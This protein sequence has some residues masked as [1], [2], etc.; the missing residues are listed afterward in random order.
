MACEKTSPWTSVSCAAV[1]GL[2]AS[3]TVEANCPAASSGCAPGRSLQY[4][5]SFGQ[6][7]CV[8]LRFVFVSKTS[9][10]TTPS[11][12]TTNWSCLDVSLGDFAFTSVSAYSMFAQAT[13]PAVIDVL[14]AWPPSGCAASAEAQDQTKPRHRAAAWSWIGPRTPVKTSPNN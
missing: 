4:T 6:S 2:R 3:T 14:D 7:V 8:C 11:S 9:T 13:L 10:S 12:T 1:T 5:K